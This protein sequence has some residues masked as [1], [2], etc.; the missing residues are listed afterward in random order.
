MTQSFEQL[1]AELYDGSVPDWDG[2]PNW[3]GDYAFEMHG[4][5]HGIVVLKIEAGLIKH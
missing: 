1:A 2:R 5:Y 3:I 4:H